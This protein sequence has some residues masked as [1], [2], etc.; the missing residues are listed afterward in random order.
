MQTNISERTRALLLN[1][2]VY[3]DGTDLDRGELDRSD[4]EPSIGWPDDYTAKLSDVLQ[5]DHDPEQDGADLEDGDDDHDHGAEPS[6]QRSA[7]PSAERDAQSDRRAFLR[8]LASLP[9]IGGSVAILGQPTKAAVPVTRELLYTYN[10]WL[11]YEHFRTSQ[12]IYGPALALKM[13]RSWSFV[14]TAYDWHHPDDGPLPPEP[15]TRAAIVLSAVGCPL[16]G[17]LANG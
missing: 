16:D 11:Q 2:E 17:G 12:E 7:H 4:L 8:G 10:D 15:S 3:E 1:S 6:W 13:T 5:A 14:G 9:L